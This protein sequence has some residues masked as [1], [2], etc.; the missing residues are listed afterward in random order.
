MRGLLLVVV[1]AAM[2]ACLVAAMTGEWAVLTL[3]TAAMT[4]AAWAW[5]ATNYTRGT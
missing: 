2:P 4:A 3:T 5:E 1:T